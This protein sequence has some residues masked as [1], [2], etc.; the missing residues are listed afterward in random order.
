MR[1]SHWEQ[2]FSN[3]HNFRALVARIQP[4]SM[5]TRPV[6]SLRLPSKFLPFQETCYSLRTTPPQT[7]RNECRSVTFP[8][9]QTQQ[10]FTMTLRARL[11]R[12]P[13]R[14]HRLRRVCSSFKIAPPQTRKNECKSGTYRNSTRNSC[15]QSKECLSSQPGSCAS[16]TRRGER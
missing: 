11:P 8:E 15:L 10:P 9:V 7:P 14:Q 1:L 2:R 3:S 12:S 5:T 4:P 6:R 13:R 16:T